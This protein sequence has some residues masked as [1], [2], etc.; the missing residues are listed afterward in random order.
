M[1]KIFA[2][3]GVVVKELYRRKDFY[4]LFILTVIICLVMGS[5]NVFSRLNTRAM[6]TPIGLVTRKTS[7]RKNAICN[8]PLIVMSEL[9]RTQ[10]RVHE[11]DGREHTDCEHNHRFHAHKVLLTSHAHKSARKRSTAEKKQSSPRS[12]ACPA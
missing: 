7:T 8:H 10:E 11:I 2:V 4:V 3:S 1:N 6:K 12:K 9:L 5:M